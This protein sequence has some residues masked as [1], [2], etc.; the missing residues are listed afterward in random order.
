M[1]GTRIPL[2]KEQEDRLIS[3]SSKP[4][5]PSPPTAV[6]LPAYSTAFSSDHTLLS[7]TAAAQVLSPPLDGLHQNFGAFHRKLSI[8]FGR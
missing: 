7:H 6:A 8:R 5:E 2:E 3:V 4:R 1:G